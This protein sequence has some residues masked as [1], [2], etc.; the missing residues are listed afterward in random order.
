MAP[1]K[2]LH[3]NLDRP[4]FPERSES[5]EDYK[6]ALD[7]DMAY[8]DTQSALRALDR[9]IKS[10]KGGKDSKTTHYG[11]PLPSTVDEAVRRFG[12]AS[13]FS[14]DLPDG[15]PYFNWDR[16]HGG[17]FFL[18][19]PS[20]RTSRATERIMGAYGFGGMDSRAGLSPTD[21]S[22]GL[23][24]KAN[25]LSYGPKSLKSKRLDASM[26]HYKPDLKKGRK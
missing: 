23:Y 6:K 18:D 26:G 13:R 7:D 11:Q 19:E 1:K 10:G 2:S 17:P 21:V 8:L 22:E 4:D 12:G 24:E 5:Y 9:L 20:A 15:S 25:E 16:S 14:E 3:P